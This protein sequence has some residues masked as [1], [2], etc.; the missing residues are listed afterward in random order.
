MLSERT[1]KRERGTKLISIA[2]LAVAVVSTAITLCYVVFPQFIIRMFFGSSYIQGAPLLGLFGV[3]LTLYSVGNMLAMI[4]MAL[5]RLKI[6]F[7]P[8][9]CAFVQIVGITLYHD[10]VASV[11]WVNIVSCLVLV[12][13]LLGYYMKQPYEKV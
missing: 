13:S 1:A 11:I 12:V 8:I 4:F 7:I 2:L 3:F 9:V 5:G 6:W 10:S